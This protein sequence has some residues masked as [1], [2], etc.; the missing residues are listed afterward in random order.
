MRLRVL[1]VLFVLIGIGIGGVFAWKKVFGTTVDRQTELANV[2]CGTMGA[3][4]KNTADYRGGST[5]H[6]LAV[7]VQSNEGYSSERIVDTTT[8]DT[9][10]SD[11]QRSKAISEIQLVACVDRDGEQALG[12]D[13]DFDGGKS[14]AVYR[15]GY[16]VR[17]YEPKT[18]HLVADKRVEAES[19]DKFRCPTMHFDP[20]DHKI[21]LDPDD[22][23]LAAVLTPLVR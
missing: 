12:R 22:A 5:P 6:A 16:H 17:V 10:L 11:A 15:P 7:F 9:T 19:A 2:V 18:H 1:I 8:H 21:Y 14:L 13:C 23:A 3:K 20:G 4:V